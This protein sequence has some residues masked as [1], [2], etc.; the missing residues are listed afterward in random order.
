VPD[1]ANGG[2]LEYR[3]VVRGI[4]GGCDFFHMAPRKAVILYSILQLRQ[5]LFLNSA[6]TSAA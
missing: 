2:F 4:V 6:M 1:T 5:S 3:D